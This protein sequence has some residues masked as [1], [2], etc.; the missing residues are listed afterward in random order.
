MKFFRAFK[1]Q[2]LPIFAKE[3]RHTYRLVLS[4][5]RQAAQKGSYDFITRFKYKDNPKEFGF[6]TRVF[7]DADV[8][9]Y[10]SDITTFPNDQEW[11]ALYQLEHSKH[12]KQIEKFMVDL[13]IGTG[14]WG[15]IIILPPFLYMNY[16]ILASLWSAISKGVID[17]TVWSLIIEIGILVLMVLFGDRIMS[18]VSAVLMKIVQWYMN[19]NNKTRKKKTAA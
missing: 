11:Y 17:A 8:I 19:R 15:K 16:R 10:V 5:I 3:H 7:M 12:H 6:R 13:Q 4:L 1:Q 2:F 14:L 9:H 18:V